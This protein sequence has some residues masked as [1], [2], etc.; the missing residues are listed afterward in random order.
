VKTLRSFAHYGRLAAI[1]VVVAVLLVVVV[2]GMAS[3]LFVASNVTWDQPFSFH[4]HLQY[5]AELGWIGRPNVTLADAFGPGMSIRTNSQGFRENRDVNAT[6]LPGQVRIICS[7]DSFTFGD[8][9]DGDHAWCRRLAALNSRLETVNM[10]QSAYGVDQAYLWYRRAGASV[11]H[12]VHLLAFITD[13]VN[14]MR[15]D[16]F[17]G[18]PKPYLAIQDGTLTVKN[19]PVPRKWLNPW[20]ANLNGL[21]LLELVRE[22]RGRVFRTPNDDVLASPQ[23][24]Q[25]RQLLHH[26][27]RELHRTKVVAGLF[28]LLGMRRRTQVAGERRIPAELGRARHVLITPWTAGS[29]TSG[30]SVGQ[31]LNRPLKKETAPLLSKK[32][33]RVQS[34]RCAIILLR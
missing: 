24:P 11:Q 3:L 28:R 2:E 22:I 26:L 15:M 18:L 20:R 23:D 14:R 33:R 4:S 8:A 10:G 6:A 31:R 29:V 1:N 30:A 21:R 16:E 12:Q 17:S 34:S 7:G 32:R 25:T 13:N 27:L 5:D 19:V 9:V